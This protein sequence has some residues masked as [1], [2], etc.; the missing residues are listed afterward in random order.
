MFLIYRFPKIFDRDARLD[1][2][3]RGFF[4]SS[5]RVEKQQ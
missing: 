4:Y 2:F 1:N 3:L 5:A